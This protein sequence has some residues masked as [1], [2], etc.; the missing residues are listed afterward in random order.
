MW[1]IPLL[2]LARH[3][4]EGKLQSSVH[5]EASFFLLVD[6]AQEM[7]CTED[8]QLISNC[9]DFVDTRAQ[10]SLTNLSLIYSTTYPLFT[11]SSSAILRRP[12]PVSIS[13]TPARPVNTFQ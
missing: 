13:S 2:M 12:K 4:S 8:H 6:W 5:P 1:L 3:A 11:I 9:L 7:G 10:V